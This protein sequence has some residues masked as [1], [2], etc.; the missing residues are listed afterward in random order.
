[1]SFRTRTDVVPA[2]KISA[3]YPVYP[4]HRPSSPAA[5]TMHRVSFEVISMLRK[6]FAGKLRKP[7]RIPVGRVCDAASKSAECI[8]RST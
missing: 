8:H 2:H 3:Y 5:T 7:R 4:V 1:M 6:S